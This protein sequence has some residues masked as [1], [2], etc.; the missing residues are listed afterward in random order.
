M[1]VYTPPLRDMRFVLHELHGSA[2][3]STLKGLEEVTPDLIDAVLEEAGK[4]VTEVLA[5][6]NQ[7]G[8]LEGCTYENGVVRTPK[9]FKEAYKAFCAGGWNG[10]ACDPQYGGQG[11]P[12]SLNKLVE[13]MLCSGN[14]AFGICPGLTHGAYEALKNHAS[15]ELKDRF[16]P[17]MV[18]GVWSGSM[19][20]TEPQCG[21][22]LGLVRT[23]AEPK[24]DGS[25]KVTGNKIFISAGEHDMAENIIHLVLARLPDAPKGIKGIS[26][27][28]VPKFLPR[29]DGSV[30]PR[31]GV[32]CTGIEHK[33]GIHGSSTCQMSFDEATGWLVGEPHKGM[34]AMFSMMNSERLSVG[35]QGLGLG[36]AAYQAAVAYAKERLQGR[37]LSGA[38]HPDKPADPIIVHP[39]VRRTLMTMRAYNEGCR[40]LA[41]WVA[42][43]LDLMEHAQDPQE[44]QRAEDFTALMTPIVKALFTDL[45]FEATSMGM[46]VY[47][48]HGYIR[49]H[50][51]EQYVRD[52]RIAMIY[53]GTNGVQALDLVGRKLPAHMGRYLRSF[54]HP[55]LNYM[56]AKLDDENLGP[57]ITP[58]SKAFG[59]LQLATAHIAEKGLKDPEEAGAA[60]TQYLR[61]FG[62]VALGYMWVR[63]AEVAFEKRVSNPDDAAFYDAKIATA[64]FFMEKLLPDVAALWGSIKAG[65]A[66]MM[67]LDEAMF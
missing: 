21:T 39:D 4:F 63:M 67:A 29:E 11:L 64:R 26:L 51:M 60:A 32:T 28:L 1:Q 20:L 58:L 7:S 57:L 37:A 49:D 35:T 48:G 6:L 24:G 53:E 19:C 61:L 25:Y 55:V 34:R 27:F 31:N 2:E 44:R 47:G 54:F 42:R 13:E 16:L 30:G 65:K 18:D 40:A 66:S 3:L 22:D 59:A 12:A 15:Q 17:K 14:L 46:Q 36:E 10:I 62:M 8:D 52:A 56:D 50:G 33:M 41:G 9:G 38:K 43:A 23:K 45:G 5:P